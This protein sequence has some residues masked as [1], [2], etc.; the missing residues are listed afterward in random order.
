MTEAQ[1]NQLSG[2]FCAENFFEDRQVI[3]ALLRY[4]WVRSPFTKNVIQLVFIVRLN[5]WH[6]QLL[7]IE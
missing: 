6:Q 1:I 5:R 2:I 4:I 3:Q 7:R